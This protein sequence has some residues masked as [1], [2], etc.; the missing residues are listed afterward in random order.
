M[1]NTGCLTEEAN[2]PNRGPGA[3]VMREGG[4][5]WVPVE[6]RV[7][8]TLGPH[9]CHRFNEEK[10]EMTRHEHTATAVPPYNDL[11]SMWR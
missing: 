5:G 8:Q 1:I 9:G 7:R 2:R 6:R 4:H 10:F 11:R 3:L